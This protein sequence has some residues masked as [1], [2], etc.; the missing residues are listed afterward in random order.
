MWPV[1]LSEVEAMGSY[2][3]VY[4]WIG[5]C[6]FMSRKVIDKITIVVRQGF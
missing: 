2:E 1:Y 6:S 3:S 4:G 5:R